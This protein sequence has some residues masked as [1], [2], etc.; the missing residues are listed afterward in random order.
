MLKMLHAASAMLFLSAAVH[1]QTVS[2][3]TLMATPST[4]AH[5]Y[6]GTIVSFSSDVAIYGLDSNFNDDFD[7]LHI[8]AFSNTSTTFSFSQPVSSFSFDFVALTNVPG[9]FSEIITNL[10]PS[11]WAL[12][13]NSALGHETFVSGNTIDSMVDDGRGTLTFSGASFSSSS[14][15]LQHT[16]GSAGGIVLTELRYTVAVPEPV[17]ASVLAMAGLMMMRRRR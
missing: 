16:F 3:P 4:T 15:D 11:G 2:R 12:S 5:S 6:P 7:G 10:S 9:T 14:L 13:N 1:A 17:A 8:G